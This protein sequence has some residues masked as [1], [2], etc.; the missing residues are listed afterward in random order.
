MSFFFSLLLFSSVFSLWLKGNT[1]L[2]SAFQV[3]IY[4]KKAVVQS[5]LQK[6]AA[7]FKESEEE[8]KVSFCVDFLCWLCFVLFVVLQLLKWD[9]QGLASEQVE[10]K[11]A[12]LS[13]SECEQVKRWFCF[14]FSF[15]SFFLFWQT[16]AVCICTWTIWRLFLRALCDLRTFKC[17][18]FCLCLFFSHQCFCSVQTLFE[19]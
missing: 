9:N 5:L 19:R 15:F 14:F 17:A 3:D 6:L 16:N 7:H 1:A 8:K 4:D 11:I 18:L 10:A 2:P 13:Q 12:A